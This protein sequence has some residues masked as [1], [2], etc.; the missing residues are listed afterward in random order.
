[1]RVRG[2]WHESPRHG[3]QLKAH[4]VAQVTPTSADATQRYLRLFRGVG[5]KR[6]RDLVSAF[7]NIFEV[8]QS[9]PDKL[10]SV[11]GFGKA[12]LQRLLD[13]WT[14]RRESHEAAAFL[15]S[16]GIGPAIAERLVARLGGTAES[17]AKAIRE[18]PYKVSCVG[19]C[20]A[21]E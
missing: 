6:A 3:L 14:V 12:A 4:H 15:H 16:V 1:M 18:D 8:L 19:A 9:E 5:V 10:L 20:V 21:S 13:E 7:P 17:C 2:T 11:K